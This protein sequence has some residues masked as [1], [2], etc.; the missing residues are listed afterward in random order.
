MMNKLALMP[1]TTPSVRGSVPPTY[2]PESR[3]RMI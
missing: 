2:T 1:A 3:R